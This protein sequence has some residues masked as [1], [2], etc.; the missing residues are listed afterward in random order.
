MVSKEELQD[1][2]RTKKD[3]PTVIQLREYLKHSGSLTSKKIAVYL[4]GLHC[5]KC[6]NFLLNLFGI[7]NEGS[8]QYYSGQSFKNRGLILPFQPL[9]M[10]FKD[11]N[12]YVDV[13]LVH[14]STSSIFLC[15]SFCL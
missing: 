10:T 8:T 5:R 2:D 9:S 6:E 12:Y 3:E 13:P 7:Y 11:I 14:S 4:G 1:R 15:A